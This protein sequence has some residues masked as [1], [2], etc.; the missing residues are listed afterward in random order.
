LAALTSNAELLKNQADAKTL[1]HM[2]YDRWAQSYRANKDWQGAVDLYAKALQSYP[3]DGYLEN[4]AV[5]T[6]DSWARTF[7]PAKDWAQAIQIYEKA[8]ERF[9]DNG[10]LKNNLNY[11]K[12]Q[13]KKK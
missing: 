10:T 5:A 11:C 8:L 13:L 6:W 1:A 7:F 12:E 9:P 4:N 2:V 3:K